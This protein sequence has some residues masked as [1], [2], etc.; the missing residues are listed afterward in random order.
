MAISGYV[1]KLRSRVGHDFL[2][3]PAVTAVIQDG[4]R[5][6]LAR[7]RDTRRWSLIGGGIE[8]GETPEAALRRE[9]HEELGVAPLVGAIVGAYGGRRLETTYPNGDRVGYI[10]VAYRCSLPV[11][12]LDLDQDE[13]IETR[14][15]QRSDVDALHRHDWIDRV[16]DDAIC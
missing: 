6:L 7:Q 3:L 12:V 13:V 10:S 14:W 9:V 4:D 5:F 15:V 1:R 8:P 2:L 16:L 11:D